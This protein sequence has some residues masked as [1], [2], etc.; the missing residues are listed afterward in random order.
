MV[1]IKV[2]SGFRMMSQAEQ[3]SRCP[4]MLR[5]KSHG[6]FNR[7]PILTIVIGGR[8]GLFVGNS[9]ALRGPD[10]LERGVE[11]IVRRVSPFSR[12]GSA[13]A[14]CPPHPPPVRGGPVA[15]IARVVLAVGTGVPRV[16]FRLPFG[17]LAIVG[18]W[19]FRASFPV[20]PF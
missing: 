8:G 9:I 1:P 17:G 20:R 15:I 13:S 4:S 3:R 5:Q 11:P 6:P 14:S 18:A 19:R 2:Q 7:L 12:R 16:A 10:M